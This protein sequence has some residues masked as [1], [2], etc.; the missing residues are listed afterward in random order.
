MKRIAVLR[1]LKSSSHCSGAGC[2][3]IL[4]NKE[5]VYSKY[6]EEDIQLAAFWTCN[7]CGDISL[8]DEEG[9]RRKIASMER[10]SVDV[11]H[12][13]HCVFKKKTDGSEEI[14][15]QVSAIVSELEKIGVRVEKGF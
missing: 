9:L 5:K 7:G 6:K 15:T 1:C 8:G 3:K 12:M 2:L 10:F 13:S 14:C 11:V 4:F